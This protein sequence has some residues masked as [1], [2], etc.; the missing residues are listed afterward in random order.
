M[1]IFSQNDKQT[2]IDFRNYNDDRPNR[3]VP[4][5]LPVSI[6]KKITK[7]MQKLN[8]TTGSVDL[9]KDIKG[10]YVFLEINPVG[11][12]GM[13]SGPCNYYLEKRIAEFLIK[14]K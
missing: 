13:V 5:L 3:Y 2:K 10:N 4:Y 9:I 11:Q 14:N 6:E 8:L 12:F 7:L 1:A